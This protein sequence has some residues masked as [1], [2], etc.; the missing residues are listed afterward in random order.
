MSSQELDGDTY[1]VIKQA[2]IQ[3]YNSL[4]RCEI[5]NSYRGESYKGI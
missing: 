5:F 1:E 2:I 3:M 4:F